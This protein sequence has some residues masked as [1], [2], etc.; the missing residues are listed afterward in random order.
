MRFGS[1]AFDSFNGGLA[2]SY[3]GAW[4]SGITI[5]KVASALSAAWF[6][7]LLGEKI[8]RKFKH[9]TARRRASVRRGR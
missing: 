1:R 4:A 9:R 8:V 5:D 7:F 2:L 6:A 3:L